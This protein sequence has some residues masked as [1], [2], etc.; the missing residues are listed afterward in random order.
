MS[1]ASKSAI[2]SGQPAARTGNAVIAAPYISAR[3]FVLAVM[4]GTGPGHTVIG[5]SPQ[6]RSE[7]AC[8]EYV[9]HAPKPERGTLICVPKEPR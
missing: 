3:L 1:G 9:A 4:W 8:A 7:A 6:F 5:N 2:K